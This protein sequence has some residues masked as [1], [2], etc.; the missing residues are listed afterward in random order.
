LT[1]SAYGLYAEINDLAKALENATAQGMAAIFGVC[2]RALAPLLEKVEQ[3]SGGK[4]RVPDLPLALARIEEF[5]SGSA[6]PRDHSGIRE[7]LMGEIPDEHPWSTYAQDVLICVNA[8]LEAASAEGRP[9][10]IVIEY[11]LEPLVAFM[12]NR[13]AG[14]IRV[15]GKN[16]WSVQITEDP[17]MEAAINFLRDLIA[18][19]SQATSV[20]SEELKRLV[21]NASVLRPGSPTPRREPPPM[22]PSSQEPLF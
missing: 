9:K 8:G 17:A 6:A 4:W 1:G 21:S 18:E 5:A 12:Q 15:Y 22:P 13:D 14:V 11:A 10:P 20:D 2:A 16:H 7:R 19:V 3:R